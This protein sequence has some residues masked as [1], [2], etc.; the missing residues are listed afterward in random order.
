MSDK[1]NKSILD[2][3]RQAASLKELDATLAVAREI[4]VTGSPSVNTRGRWERAGIARRAEL[5]REV[6]R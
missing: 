1:K 6:K 3:I 4:M 2:Y 5:S